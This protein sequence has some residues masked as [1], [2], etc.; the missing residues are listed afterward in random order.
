MKKLL[1]KSKCPI[2][3]AT[4][5]LSTTLAYLRKFGSTDA[6]RAILGIEAALRDHINDQVEVYRCELLD[7]LIGIDEGEAVTQEI[8]TI[9]KAED[10]SEYEEPF[11]DIV[12]EAENEEEAEANKQADLALDTY[13]AAEEAERATRRA[14]R[15]NAAMFAGLC[16][17]FLSG[18]ASFI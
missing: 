3:M 7:E 5:D 6:N 1:L 17:L 15:I 9:H 18:V 11:E 16:L 10:T 13:A 8:P 2:L 4:E 14:M 12:L